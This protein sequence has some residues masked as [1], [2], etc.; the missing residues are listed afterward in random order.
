MLTVNIIGI[1]SNFGLKYRLSFTLGYLKDEAIIYPL[2]FRRP[3]PA[4]NFAFGSAVSNIM[5]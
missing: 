5:I 4:G 1:L 2:Q 3:V